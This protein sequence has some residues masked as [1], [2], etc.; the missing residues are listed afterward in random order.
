MC[1]AALVLEIALYLKHRFWGGYPPNLRLDLGI[2][3][4]LLVNIYLLQG[5]KEIPK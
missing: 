2:F 4:A 3:G 5:K 1:V